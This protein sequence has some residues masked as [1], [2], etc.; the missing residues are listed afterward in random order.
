MSCLKIIKDN[1]LR[2]T[3]QRRLIIDILHDTHTHLTGEDIIKQ[4]Q[5]R[6]PGVNKST[7]YR[8]LDMLE[9]TGCV[10]KSESG[11]RSIYHHAEEGH[12]HHLVCKKCGKVVECE[13][14]VFHSVENALLKNY[15]FHVGFKHFVMNGLCA[16]CK[17]SK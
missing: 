11:N 2:L 17:N 1:G 10:F 4:V 5:A 8:T 3:P 15:G 7:I 9:Q 12:H 14:N 16:D 6:M 13:E